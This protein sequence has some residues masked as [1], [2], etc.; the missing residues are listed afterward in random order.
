[1][2]RSS[3]LTRES[4]PDNV[5]FEP[6]PARPDVNGLVNLTRRDRLSSLGKPASA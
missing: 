3:S 6:L 1:V 2:G 5:F 4:G